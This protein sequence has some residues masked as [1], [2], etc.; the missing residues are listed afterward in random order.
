MNQWMP[1][2]AKTPGNFRGSSRKP[3]EPESQ[4]LC[5]FRLYSWW[6]K[7]CT[8]W[9]LVYPTIYR[10][11]YIPGG[12]GFL[13]LHLVYYIGSFIRIHGRLSL[14]KP[15]I[16][17][18][19]TW[20]FG[21]ETGQKK[22]THQTLKSRKHNKHQMKQSKHYMNIYKYIIYDIS[23]KL[24]INKYIQKSSTL[25]FSSTSSTSMDVYGSKN[26]ASKVPITKL[27][28]FAASKIMGW[29]KP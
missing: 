6:K 9:Y 8:S 26:T 15:C 27:W 23:M 24:W 10:V 18:K 12:A 28:S 14:G 2:E 13:P 11:L 5:F 29:G 21:T 22:R 16:C 20:A 1:C 3:Q 4:F 17:T 7:S 19:N 25:V